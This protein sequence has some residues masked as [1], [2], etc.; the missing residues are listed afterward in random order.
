VAVLIRLAILADCLAT[1]RP[2]LRQRLEEAGIE[3][4]RLS[5]R[6]SPNRTIYYQ[7]A[8]VIHWAEARGI[9]LSIPTTDQGA[10][11]SAARPARGPSVRTP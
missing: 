5:D 10:A 1:S 2:T 8:D 3:A 4:I 11:A 7:I 9:Q 6:P